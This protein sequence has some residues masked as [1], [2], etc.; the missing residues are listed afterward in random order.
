[1]LP[2]S[3]AYRSARF[4]LGVERSTLPLFTPLCG[5]SGG[6]RDCETFIRFPY[7]VYSCLGSR[8]CAQSAGEHLR[9]RIE[10][11]DSLYDRPQRKTLSLNIKSGQYALDCRLHVCLLVIA[12]FLS[13]QDGRTAKLFTRLR[14]NLVIFR[15]KKSTM[16][17][18]SIKKI[19][20]RVLITAAQ[21]DCRGSSF[22]RR[23]LG[24]SFSVLLPAVSLLGAI[25]ATW[26]ISLRLEKCALSHRDACHR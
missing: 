25:S 5:A 26:E 1:M 11:L 16:N 7:E 6:L 18:L 8:Y 22:G 15:E 12:D 4:V 14:L 20:E 9:E 21:H 10:S 24:D 23:I 17:K 3:R 13:Q 2:Q 19:I